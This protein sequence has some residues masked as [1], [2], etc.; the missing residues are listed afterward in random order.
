MAE[1][2]DIKKL[3][4]RELRDILLIAKVYYPMEQWLTL[5][6]LEHLERQ[7]V[8]AYSIRWGERLVGAALIMAD[9][10]PN[11]WLEFMVIDRNVSRRG[12]GESLFLAAERD[13]ESG[14]MLWHH[15]PANK[16]FEPT[17]K[18]LTKMGMD[19]RGSLR[20]WFGRTDAAVYA[21]RIR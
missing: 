16:A 4:R 10:H 3:K 19:E 15:T 11:F 14:S 20:G 1:P 13:L 6:Y 18:F 7:A 17:R 9:Q 5:D 12:L 21:K 2:I 8:V